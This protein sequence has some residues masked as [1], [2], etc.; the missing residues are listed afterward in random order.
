MVTTMRDPAKSVTGRT[1]EPLICYV[2]PCPAP[3]GNK[4]GMVALSC[5]LQSLQD[6][7]STGTPALALPQRFVPTV[8]A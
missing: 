8:T 1:L 7:C 6:F 5:H 3:K 4:L 2:T